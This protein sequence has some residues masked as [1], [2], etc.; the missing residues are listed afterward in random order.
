MIYHLYCCS[1]TFFSYLYLL[2]SIV[3]S[4][5]TRVDKLE[6]SK[7]NIDNVLNFIYNLGD[8]D[9]ESD[10]HLGHCLAAIA[11]GQSY[12]DVV[13]FPTPWKVKDEDDA[14]SLNKHGDWNTDVK[15]ITLEKYW[16]IVQAE[17][18]KVGQKR[19]HSACRRTSRTI[20]F[21][22]PGLLPSCRGS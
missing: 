19:L 7:Q 1:F 5:M 6:E 20:F 17:F 15:H 9:E 10:K 2:F 21:R 3:A 11:S 12:R 4:K 18:R 22:L 16:D 13:A 14:G 8:R